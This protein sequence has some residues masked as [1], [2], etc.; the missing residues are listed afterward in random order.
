MVPNLSS[1]SSLECE[2]CQLGKHSCSSFPSR[3]NKRAS[4][5][6]LVVHSDVWGP[7]RVSSKEGFRYFVTFIDDF[8]ELYGYI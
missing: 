3:V 8:L 5:P 1:I 7:S 2:S 6:F 4:S